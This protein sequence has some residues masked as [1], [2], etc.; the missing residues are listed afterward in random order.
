MQVTAHFLLLILEMVYSFW[1]EG[2]T[3]RGGR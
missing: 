3:I 2:T 1:P